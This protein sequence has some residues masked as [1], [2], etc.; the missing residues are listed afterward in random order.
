MATQ[1]GTA[2]AMELLRPPPRCRNGFPAVRAR[3]LAVYE[4]A[5]LADPAQAVPLCEQASSVF[6]DMRAVA[7]DFPA[8]TFA[9]F[10][11]REIDPIVRIVNTQLNGR[12]RNLSAEQKQTEIDLKQ[13]ADESRARRG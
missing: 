13:L 11:W 7:E 6:A 4:P 12:R 9:K 5:M 2:P 10:L 3:I 1:A 8:G